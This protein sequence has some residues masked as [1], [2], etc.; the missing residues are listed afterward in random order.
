MK[1]RDWEIGGYDRD[2]AVSLYRSGINPLS[3]VFLA[4]RGFTDVAEARRLLGEGE[5]ETFDPFLLTDMDKAVKRIEAALERGERIAVYGDYDVDGMTSCAVL[6]LWLRSRNADYQIYIP[7]RLDEGYGL[8]RAA[9]DLL[10]SRGVDLIITVDCGITGIG[11]AEYARELGF[12]L[13]ITD[14][15]ECRNRLPAADAVIDPKRLDCGYPYKSLAGVGVAFKLVCALERDAD[16]EELLDRCCDLVAIGTIADVMPVVGENR[17]FIKRGLKLLRDAPRPGLRSLLRDSGSEP[18]KIT[19]ETVGYLLAPRLNA[20]GRMGCPDLSVELLLTEDAK[21]ADALTAELCRLNTQRRVM[22]LEILGQ[23]ASMLP[24][25]V[26][27]E[28]IVLARQGWHQGVTGIVA[29]KISE[30]HCVPAI[31]ISIDGNGVG[32]G[33]CRS[34]GTFKIYDALKTCED[35]LDNYGGHDMAAGITLMEKNIDELRGRIAAYYR[36]HGCSADAVGLAVDFVVEKPQLL[37]VPNVGAIGKLEP[38]GPGFPTPRLCLKDALVLSAYTIGSGKHARLRIGKG[39]ASFDCVCFGK[40]A[41]ELGVADGMA[42]DAAFE[43]QIN[44]Y[45]G[46]SSVQLMLLDIKVID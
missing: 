38:F 3:A 41:E 35:I 18:G 17:E 14:H 16:R 32:R 20:A 45:R 39:K 34:Y 19:T 1:H 40:S 29:A 22:E 30:R 9:L 7:G 33:S 10:K 23:A 46:R 25:T 28:P 15:H 44:D 5:T 26:A 24:E 37:T 8:N 13:I 12:G 6:A 36:A 43:P 27:D 11:E 31:V 2:A 42:I 4:S 21:T